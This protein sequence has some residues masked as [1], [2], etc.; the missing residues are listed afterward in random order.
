MDTGGSHCTEKSVSCWTCCAVPDGSA[1]VSTAKTTK[2]QARRRQRR[3]RRLTVWVCASRVRRWFR[4]LQ[5]VLKDDPWRGLLC[6]VDREKSPEGNGLPDA[7][8]PADSGASIESGG[9]GQ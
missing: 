5:R 2:P 8:A 6:C 9:G 3:S 4:E 7:Q 1:Q